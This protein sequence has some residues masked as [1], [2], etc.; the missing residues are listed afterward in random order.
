MKCVILIT[1]KCHFLSMAMICEKGWECSRNALNRWGERRM[2]DGLHQREIHKIVDF[3]PIKKQPLRLLFHFF[4]LS[5][6]WRC[7]RQ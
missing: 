4:G 2:I 1:K 7:L 6:S 3:S 5:F